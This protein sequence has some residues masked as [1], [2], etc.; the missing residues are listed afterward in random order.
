[1]LYST[2][3][4]NVPYVEHTPA[5]S[6]SVRAVAE[7]ILRGGRMQALFLSCGGESVLLVTCPRGGGNLSWGSRR[8]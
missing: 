2:V 7:I 8:I 6:D 4:T 1:M 5:I 3:N